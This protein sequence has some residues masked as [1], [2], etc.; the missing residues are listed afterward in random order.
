MYSRLLFWQ[1]IFFISSIQLSEL[2]EGHSKAYT[3]SQDFTIQKNVAEVQA[4]YLDLEAFGEIHPLIKN[5]ECLVDYS[6]CYKFKVIEKPFNWLPFKINYIA[7]I[8]N[9]IYLQKVTYSL[10]EIP[11]LTPTINYYLEDVN[12]LE[13]RMNIEIEVHGSW[14]FRR[15]LAK[16][17]MKAQQH[18]I[19]TL[20][21]AN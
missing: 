11:F 4:F 1:F 3:I 18:I 19:A 20:N 7:G 12:Q 2:H 14:I 6:Q 10:S 21:T 5:V 16:K 15:Y 8:E 9:P 13:T 17:I